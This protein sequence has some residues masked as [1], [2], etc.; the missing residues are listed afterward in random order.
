MVRATT[1]L[2]LCSGAAFAQDMPEPP[3]NPN[4]ILLADPL[5]ET[6]GDMYC[7]DVAGSDVTSG[8]LMQAHTCKDPANDELFTTDSPRLGNVLV[9]DHD[10]CVLARRVEAGAQL[11]IGACRMDSRQ[12]WISSET[13]QIHPV[14]DETL[15]WTVSTAPRGL[16]AGAGGD[17]LKRA[18]TLQPCDDFD[19]K[20]NTWILPGGHVG[21]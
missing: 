15:C 16:P 1:L 10:L 3:A 21:I 11:N 17:H 6:R 8:N 14:D 5:D 18:L 2:F 19:S 13:G 4:F 7:A 12:R 9:T 20:Y